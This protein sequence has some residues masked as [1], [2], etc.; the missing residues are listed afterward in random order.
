[1]T[2]RRRA[3]VALLAVVWVG[4]A[5]PSAPV[6]AQDRAAVESAFR[7]WVAAL[8]PEA[9]AA[10]VSARTFDREMASAGLEWS[11]PDL[12]PPGREQE[13]D[14]TRVRQTE[15][16]SPGAYFEPGGLSR[17]V[18][19][20][21]AELKKWGRTLAAIEKRYGVPAPVLVAIWARESAFGRAAIPHDAISV[22]ATQA[23]MG[24]RPQLFRPQLVAALKLL[25]D[26]RV[27]RAGLKSSWA[28]AMGHMQMMPAQALRYGV[29]FDGDGRADVWTSVPDALASAAN[30]LRRKGWAADLPWGY[31]V[32][33]P[34]AV[35]CSFEGPHQGRPAAEWVALG[36]TRPN[37]ARLAGLKAGQ[38]GFLL[39]PAGRFGPSFLVSANFYVLKEYNNSDLYALYVGHLADR[40]A[41]D[42]PFEG[43][44]AKVPTYTRAEVRALQERLVAQGYNVGDS[45]DGL[46]GFRTRVAVGLY[47][48]KS[49][50]AV[51]CWPGPETLA[52]VAR[53]G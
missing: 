51:D 11:I 12:V 20:G 22:L 32:R 18:R 6:A 50:L 26:G 1:M 37:G 7:Q 14:Q 43:R 34:E 41:D 44:W 27:S 4:I 48:D 36:I 15:F 33:T 16:G 8:R 19:D 29:D 47:Q 35:A 42:R 13:I 21:R 39:M 31:E 38:D 10:G 24:R 25:E 45:I 9:L 40:L 49:G 30:F 3:L 53:Q 2:S 17:S 52:S 46:I 5:G 23:F 28:G